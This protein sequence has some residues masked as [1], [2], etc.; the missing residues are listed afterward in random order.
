VIS[1]PAPAL[2]QYE[3]EDLVIRIADMLFAGQVDRW[4][5]EYGL[6]LWVD[7]DP[8]APDE[9]AEE[10]RAIFQTV[11]GVLRSWRPE[12]GELEDERRGGRGAGTIRDHERTT[13]H[14]SPADGIMTRVSAPS[15]PRGRRHGRARFID[16]W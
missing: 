12:S 14:R 13:C 8:T 1:F 5:N 16:G 10:A 7:G 9:A 6:R 4:P 3:D 2:C 11:L 15:G